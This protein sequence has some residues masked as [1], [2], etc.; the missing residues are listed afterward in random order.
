MTSRLRSALQLLSFTC[1]CASASAQPI[2]TDFT[3]TAGRPGDQVILFG[4]GF[5]TPGWTIRFW[6]GKVVTSGSV[7]SDSQVTV[8]APVGITSGPIS[9]QLGTGTENFTANDFTAIGA[10]PYVTDVTP[11]YARISDSVVITGVHFAGVAK[12]G[13]SF[14]GRSSTDALPNADGTL[15]NVHVPLGATNGFLSVTTPFGTSNSP[16][17]FTVLGPGPFIAGFTPKIGAAGTTVTLTGV[18]FT[19]VTNISFGSKSGVNIV[20]QSDTLLKV[21]APPG[22]VSG[23]LTV[24]SLLGSFTTSSNFFVPPTITGFS[25]ANGRAGTNVLITG[26]SFLGA[27]AVSFNGAAAAGFLVLNNTNILTAPQL[28]V[29]SG[30]IR[31]TAPAGSAFSSNTF[32]VLPTISGVSPSAGAPGTSVLITGANLNVGTPVVRFNGVSAAAPTGVS[33]G[34]LT[35]VVPNGATTGPISVTTTDG[36]YTNAD[37]FYLPPSIAGF[38]PTNGPA[39]TR[40]RITGQGFTGATGVKF[41]GAA[42]ASFIISNDVTASAVVPTSVTTGPVSVTTPAGTATTASWFYGAPVITNFLPTHGLPGTNVTLTGSSFLGVTSVR[43]N[44]V[45]ALF[46]VANNGQITTTVPAG[47][48]NGPITVVAPGGTNITSTSFLLDY[49]ADLGVSISG[50]PNPVTVGSNIVYT[51]KVVNNGPLAAPNVRLTNTLPNSAAIKSVTL[52][53]NWLGSTNTNP[54]E[55]G[56]VSMAANSSAT[57]LVTVAPQQPGPFASLVGVGSDYTDSKSTNDVASVTTTVSPLALLG[58][59]TLGSQIRLSWSL[60]LTNYLLESNPDL[61]TGTPWSAVT[62]PPVVLGAVQYVTVTNQSPA[63]FYRLH[64]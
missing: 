19:G 2:I 49:F 14:G 33:F 27:T 54:I 50:T 31:V 22:V 4:H 26:T 7:I 3:P 13:V 23:P 46:T 39:G 15:I 58:I 56:A 10:G 48:Q 40:V 1:L 24:K 55:V 42:A 34:Q 64:K 18:G 28:G 59:Q 17:P 6:S 47:A 25:P 8:V 52:P 37:P 35:A 32:V 63:S 16:A 38:S 30:T 53:A 20:A 12:N 9:I 45:S 41:N 51:I 36:S 62:T 21:D 29:T 5:T 44:G 61:A 57:L 11:A 43:F 60:A